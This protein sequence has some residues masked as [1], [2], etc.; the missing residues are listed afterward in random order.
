MCDVAVA[1]G[2]QA[3]GAVIVLDGCIAGFGP[4]RVVLD[5]NEDAHA[6]RVALW[7]AQKRLGPRGIAG[8]E[9]HSTSRPCA[10]CQAALAKATPKNK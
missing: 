4:S 2:D 5:A 3:Y 9:I 10:I 6:E 8:A 7:D 1:S